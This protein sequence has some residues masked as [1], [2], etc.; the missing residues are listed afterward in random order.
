MIRTSGTSVQLIQTNYLWCWYLYLC[1]LCWKTID[2]CFCALD[3]NN[4]PSMIIS[5]PFLGA[6]NFNNLSS[7]IVSSSKFCLLD[8]SLNK[9]N[10]YPFLLSF[11]HNF[12]IMF[13]HSTRFQYLENFTYTFNNTLVGLGSLGYHVLFIILITISGA[14]GCNAYYQDNLDIL[15]YFEY[16]FELGEYSG[17]QP[18]WVPNYFENSP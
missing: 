1:V 11:E 12:N 5:L 16:C 6:Y 15:R 10:L 3:R 14:K 4:I 2:N 8:L 9:I 7:E 17:I 13:F 18:C